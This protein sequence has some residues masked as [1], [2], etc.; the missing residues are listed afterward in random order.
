MRE[1]QENIKTKR[2]LSEENLDNNNF[3]LETHRRNNVR[4]K[5]KK[6]VRKHKKR[7]V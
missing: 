4:N 7:E 6:H 2:F 3:A 1:Q 5:S